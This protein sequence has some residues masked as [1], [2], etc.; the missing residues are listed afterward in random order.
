M[1]HFWL[2][3]SSYAQENPGS[4]SN[5]KESTNFDIS[6]VKSIYFH[7]F[8]FLEVQ[9]KKSLIWLFNSMTT[10]ELSI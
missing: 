2:Y 5:K 9:K 3:V 7:P 6:S 10:L 4:S 8:F 1:S